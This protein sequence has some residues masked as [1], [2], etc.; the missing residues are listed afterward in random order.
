MKQIDRIIKRTVEAGSIESL[1]NYDR[2]VKVSK[3]SNEYAVPSIME[4]NITPLAI[5]F[6]FAVEVV[7]SQR[8][9]ALNHY[10]LDMFM[11]KL[12]NARRNFLQE[13]LSK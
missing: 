1:L 10:N 6:T 12:M 4:L 11:H 9:D 3:N 5:A 13:I 8:I 2:S 7:V